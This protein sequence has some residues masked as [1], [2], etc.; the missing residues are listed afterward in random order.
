MFGR[1]VG[2]VQE[3]EPRCYLPGSDAKG[4]PG[5]QQLFI[6]E[7]RVHVFVAGSPCVMFWPQ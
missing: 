3:P 2:T 7:W 1:Q 6:G 4:E 5:K